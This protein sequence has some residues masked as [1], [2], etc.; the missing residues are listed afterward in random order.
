MVMAPMTR[1]RASEEGVPGPMN[2]EYYRQRA[3]A[4][5]V[6]TECTQI[7]PQSHGIIRG[8]GIHTDKQIEGW[9]LVT[10]TVHEE[11]GRIFLQVYHCGRISHPDLL[12]GDLP[13]APSAIPAEGEFF[14][15]DGMKD[16]PTPRALET[17]EIPGIVADFGRASEN[18]REAGFDGVELHGAFGYLPDQF[19]QS[20]TNDRTDR[21]GGSV[22]NRARFHL[23]VVEALTSP[24]ESERV[25]VKLSPSNRHYGMFDEDAYETFSYL[26]EKLDE[27]E[28]AY[29]HIMEPN[30]EDMDSGTVQIEETTR[31]FRPHA[32]ETTMIANGGFDKESA[33]QILADDAADLVSFGKL[34]L[35]NPDLPKR[36]QQNGPLNEPDPETFYGEGSEGYTDY[37]TLEAVRN[38]AD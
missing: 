1:T 32:P 25:G 18:A 27:M 7:S 14:T 9:D 8:P 5:L 16:Y 36:F 30:G 34:F 12:D 17:D 21:Y 23:E 15:P 2:A 37:P 4:G 35:A 33:N 11:G 3:S 24:W 31:T 6:V 13:V 20:G 28:L 22:E 26:V 38:Q 19:L 10:E 29:I